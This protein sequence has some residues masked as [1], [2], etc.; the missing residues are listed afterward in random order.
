MAVFVVAMRRH[1][2]I[3]LP[4][5]QMIRMKP[6]DCVWDPYLVFHA[7]RQG[8]RFLQAAPRDIERCVA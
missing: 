7:R 4:S 2:D 6:G 3:S 5:K 1:L 8:V